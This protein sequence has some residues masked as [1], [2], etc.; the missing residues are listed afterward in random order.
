MYTEKDVFLARKCLLRTAG[1]M[2]AVLAVLLAGYAAALV[3]GRYAPAAVLAVVMLVF[4]L[5]F[6][7]LLLMPRLRYARFLKEMGKGL[8]RSADCVLEHVDAAVQM[9]D[10][11]KVHALQVRLADGDSRIYYLN[12]SKLDF[13]P[14]MGTGI[15]VVSYGRHVVEFMVI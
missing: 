6:G 7:D 10:G 8:R 9:Q 11:V 5:F 12:A 1:W 14:E 4:G 2:T 15:R 3:Q 13:L